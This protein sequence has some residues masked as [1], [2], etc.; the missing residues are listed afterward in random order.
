MPVARSVLRL[1][2][3]LYRSVTVALFAGPAVVFAVLV[4]DALNPATL[5]QHFPVV[6]VPPN[7]G[8]ALAV[9]IAGLLPLAA[10]LFALWE[11]RG[12]LDRYRAG[13]I[14]TPVCA[15]HLVRLGVG[16]FALA[17]LGVVAETLRTLAI[18][19]ANPPGQRILAISFGTDQMGF[20]LAGAFLLV[21]GRAMR[22]AARVAAENEA[23]V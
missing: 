20:L 5:A 7:A 8:T 14:L 22:D 6:Q 9:G 3:L 13:E 12:L 23:F 4:R 21:M 2:E 16:L 11:M 17:I 1:S 10:L 18:S 19:W 15:D